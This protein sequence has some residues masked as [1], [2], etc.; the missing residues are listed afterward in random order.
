MKQEKVSKKKHLMDE[1]LEREDK[2]ISN[3]QGEISILFN[4]PKYVNLDELKDVQISGEM[5]FRSLRVKDH[6]KLSLM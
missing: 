5:T 3:K 1:I 2:T 4:N 6:L